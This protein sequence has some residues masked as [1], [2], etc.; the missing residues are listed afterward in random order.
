MTTGNGDAAFKVID[1]HHQ[2]LEESVLACL[3]EGR[4]GAYVVDPGPTSC[5]PALEAGLAAAGFGVQDLAGLL[6]THIHLDHA[7]ASGTLARMNPRL[8]IYV[9]ELGSFHLIN[10]AKLLGSATRLY[11]DRM[12]RLWGEVAPVPGDRVIDLSGGER[13]D[14]GGRLLEVA[15]TPGHAMHHVCYFEQATGTVYAG[16]T[17]GVRTPKLPVVLPV[18]PPPDFDLQA[19][20]ESLERIAAWKPGRIVVTHF[21]AWTDVTKHLEALR[22]GL[23]AWAGYVREGLAADGSDA[24]RVRAFAARLEQWLRGR[25]PADRAA[26]FL[27]GEEPE[28]CWQGLARYWRT[29][30]SDAARPGSRP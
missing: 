14:L 13:L 23:V 3:I 9:H 6:L 17:G 25:V 5:L 24:D 16:D 22:D 10:P 27:S 29:R 7:G 1:L 11:G 18:T 28:A 15:S 20:L 4:D 2:G 30:A 21:G 12:D 8:K 26:E 19:W